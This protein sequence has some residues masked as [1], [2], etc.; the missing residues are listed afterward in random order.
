MCSTIYTMRID[1]LREYPF[2]SSSM[3]VSYKAGVSFFGPR[4]LLYSHYRKTR[5][6]SVDTRY[7]LV[8]PSWSGEQRRKTEASI[9]CRC[10]CRWLTCAN[11]GCKRDICAI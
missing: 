4:D 3:S 1:G 10:L 11:S 7:A 9:R 2:N 8:L 5:S 6:F